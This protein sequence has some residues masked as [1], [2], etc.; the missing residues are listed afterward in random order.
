M[1]GVRSVR[2]KYWTGSARSLPHG[3]RLLDADEMELRLAKE[4]ERC[5][6]YLLHFTMIAIESEALQESSQMLQSF[7]RFVT[8]RLRLSDEAGLLRKGGIGLMLPMTDAEGAK[9]VLEL[10]QRFANEHSISIRAEIYTYAGYGVN[11]T[12]PTGP[13]KGDSDAVRVELADYRLSQTAKGHRE[14]SLVKLIAK[15]FPRWKRACDIAGSVAGLVL[16]APVLAVACLAVKATSK[17]PIFF[18]QIRCGQHGRPFAIYKLRTM[19]VDAEDLK[20]LLQ[21]RNER[22][23]PAFKIKDDPRVTTVGKFLRKIGADELPQL[24]NVL[25]G[26]MSIVGPRP[27]PVSEDIQCA[28]W[29][30]KRLDTKPGLTCTWQISKSRNISFRD[31]MRLDL[32][33]GRKRALLHDIGLIAKTFGAVFLGRVGH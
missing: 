5:D 7:E 1:L 17:G 12:D 27:L 10:V 11:E 2:K 21:E 8:S 33:Y 18:K 23:G 20:A 15:P 13:E 29:Q 6:R 24:V 32:Q 28:S 31:W 30:R 25:K 4:R 9:T 19:V 3:S 26:D 16:T 14:D 22:D